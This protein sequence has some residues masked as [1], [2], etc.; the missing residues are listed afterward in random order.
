MLEAT[1]RCNGQDLEF[2]FVCSG[3]P[4]EGGRE[5]QLIEY[6]RRSWSV[7]RHAGNNLVS[8]FL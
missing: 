6:T 2:A 5:G 7:R 8:L 3:Q 1:A 4:G